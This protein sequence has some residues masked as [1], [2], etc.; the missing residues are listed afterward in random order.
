[1]CFFFLGGELNCDFFKGPVHFL[2]ISR[3]EPVTPAN[4]NPNPNPK[5]KNKEYETVDH[6]INTHNFNH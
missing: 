6:K 4:P 3:N 5:K 1:M 2:L